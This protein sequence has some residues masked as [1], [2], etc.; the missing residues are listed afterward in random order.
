MS[1]AKIFG[2]TATNFDQ[3]AQQLEGSG[4]VN[5]SEF[6]SVYALME[7]LDRCDCV[8]SVKNQ[9]QQ[10]E[11]CEALSE[12]AANSALSALEEVVR[13]GIS[14]AEASYNEL[15]ERT[16]FLPTTI[17]NTAFFSSC[18]TF[19]ITKRALEILALPK[20]NVCQAGS[21]GRALDEIRESIYASYPAEKSFSVA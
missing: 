14:Q 19:K 21:D 2:F 16:S 1:A 15:L 6:L 4:N 20:G 3:Y 17:E 12:E 10:I 18:F 5:V 7:F 11:D 8:V 9:M 13:M